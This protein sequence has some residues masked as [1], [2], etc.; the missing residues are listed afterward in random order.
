MRFT[1]PGPKRIRID[2]REGAD[3]D[4]T[5]FL[6]EAKYFEIEIKNSKYSGSWACGSQNENQR[7]QIV[8]EGGFHWEGDFFVQLKK[9]G[10]S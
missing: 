10:L 1:F 3:H 8:R 4:G 2:Y 9:V 6:R 5:V 7:C